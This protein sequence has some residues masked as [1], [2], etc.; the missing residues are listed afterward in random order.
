MTTQVEKA[1]ARWAR[2]RQRLLE[3]G[4]ETFARTGVDGA[5]V[6]DIVRAAGVSQPSFYNH[7]ATKDELAREIAADFFRNDKRAKL[8]VFDEIDD[9]A[10]A[11]AINIHHTLSIATEDPV[12]VATL[13]KSESLR[14][15]LI[16]SSAD[17]LV[18]M[19]KIGVS[20]G[21]FD[22][23]SPHT[24]ALVIRGAA[25]ALMQDILNETADDNA[26]TYFQELTLRMLGLTAA[27]STKVAARS[28]AWIKSRLDDVA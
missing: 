3:G 14:D 20:K 1:D 7:F 12:I 15:L 13:I 24:L 22:V 4:R 25:L 23:A 21:R 10:E 11:I 26:S 6:L 27:E 5:T 19:I 18:D 17:P 16:S 8:A 2:T 28:Q 9:P